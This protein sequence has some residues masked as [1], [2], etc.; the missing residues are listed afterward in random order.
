[1]K[2][3]EIEAHD[4]YEYL[5]NECR[6]GYTINN[7]LMPNDAYVRCY[8]YLP[9]LFKVEPDFG[10]IAARQLCEECISRE[11][12]L[13]FCDGDDDK[14]GNRAKSIVFIKWLLRWL[15]ENGYPYYC[16]YNYDLYLKNIAIDDKPQYLVSELFGYDSDSHTYKEAKL[17]NNGQPLSKNKYVN[18]L[19]VDVCGAKEGQDIAYNTISLNKNNKYY[20]KMV[21]HFYHMNEPI[22]RV[23]LVEKQE[24]SK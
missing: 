21:K 11:L 7:H 1:M 24:K 9:I 18:Y 6:Q 3:V 2:K 16:P 17:L 5:L 23:F 20:G 4:L 15:S 14:N 13:H 12:T 8:K 22:N 19:F 10:L